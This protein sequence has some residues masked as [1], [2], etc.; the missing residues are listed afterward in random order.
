MASESPLSPFASGA[1]PVVQE[2]QELRSRMGWFLALGIILMLVGAAAIGA[3]FITTL[4]VTLTFGILLIVGG[5]LEFFVAFFARRWSGF[6]VHLLMSLF[7]LV[8]GF[9]MV[10]NPVKGAAALTL[11]MAAIFLVGGLL[12]IVYGIAYR[13]NGRGWLI[14]TGV[15]A[16]LLGLLIWL[17]WPESATW[18]IGLFVGID[19]F[20]IGASWV[21]LA[22]AIRQAIPKIPTDDGSA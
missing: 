16:F 13:F 18:V 1:D 9:L 20:F 2:L 12:R 21:M 10:Q 19:V 7:Y 3:A 14:A 11:M 4:A 6:F 17:Q 5:A 8:V 15:V 22:V